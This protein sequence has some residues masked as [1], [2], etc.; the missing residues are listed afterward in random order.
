MAVSVSARALPAPAPST[1]AGG[2]GDGDGEG[3]GEG[4]GGDGAGGDVDSGEAFGE[5]DDPARESSSVPAP[6]PVNSV[7]TRA[8]A[9]VRIRERLEIDL[10]P[11]G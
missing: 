7:A 10:K 9:T 5:S 11:D 2:D 1:I 8:A 6:H 4:V 3:E